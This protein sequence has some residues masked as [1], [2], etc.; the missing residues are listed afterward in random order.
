MGKS[1]AASKSNGKKKTVEGMQKV[2][3][4]AKVSF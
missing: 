2:H 1:S 4:Q 3:V